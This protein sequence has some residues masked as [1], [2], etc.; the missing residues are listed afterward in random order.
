MKEKHSVINIEIVPFNPGDWSETITKGR[1]SN[2]GESLLSQPD[3]GFPTK[4]PKCGVL[5]SNGTDNREWIHNKKD[6]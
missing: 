1:C 4:C 2:C 6:S 5:L 3:R